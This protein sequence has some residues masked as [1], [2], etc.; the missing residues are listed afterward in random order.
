MRT[1]VLLFASLLLG[2]IAARAQGTAFTYQGRLNDG[3]NRRENGIR[4][5]I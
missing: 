3:T 4:K 2:A 1:K 5:E